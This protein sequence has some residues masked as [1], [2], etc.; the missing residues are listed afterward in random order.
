[1][2]AMND[3]DRQ[4][5]ARLG[6]PPRLSPLHYEVLG[7]IFMH[8]EP[9]VQRD[10]ILFESSAKSMEVFQVIDDLRRIK[11]IEIAPKTLGLAWT[12]A[13]YRLAVNRGR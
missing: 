11:A 10:K 4:F 8:G 13:A 3:S 5:A 1:M 6:N 2:P 7:I 12:K 9:E